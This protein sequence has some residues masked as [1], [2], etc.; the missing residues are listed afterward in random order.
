M[1]VTWEN[2]GKLNTRHAAVFW[3][4]GLIVAAGSPA[5]RVAVVEASDGMRLD[6]DLC[7]FTCEEWPDPADVVESNSTRSAILQDLLLL[8]SGDSSIGGAAHPPPFL[9][10]KKSTQTR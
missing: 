7:C 6:Q 9:E 4:K 1:G 5:R 8:N 10:K 2:F 3:R